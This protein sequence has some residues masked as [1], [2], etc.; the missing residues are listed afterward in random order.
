MNI[1]NKLKGQHNEFLCHWNMYVLQV[2]KVDTFDSNSDSNSNS[3]WLYIVERDGMY[4]DQGTISAKTCKL[5]DAVQKCFDKIN[6][7]IDDIEYVTEHYL[8]HL[9]T[10]AQYRECKCPYCGSKK[11]FKFRMDFD[12][13][14]GVDY[15]AV[16]D[17]KYYTNEEF[18]YN[19]FDKPNVEIYHCGD[20]DHFFE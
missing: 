7:D 14:S 20:C 8:S 1:V 4:I 11:I 16:N 9:K 6:K 12:R 10:L 13:T 18:E 5:S 2:K 17:R 19:S 15:I 3:D